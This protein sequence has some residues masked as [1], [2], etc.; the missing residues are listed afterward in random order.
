[1]SKCAVNAMKKRCVGSADEVAGTSL[2]KPRLWRVGIDGRVLRK[3][4]C[5][6]LMTGV[7]QENRA[8]LG[9]QSIDEDADEDDVDNDRRRVGGDV[10]GGGGVDEMIVGMRKDDKTQG[11]GS[12]SGWWW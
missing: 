12:G 4:T 2:G 10:E 9:F 8:V 3:G 7:I 6:G 1:M 5:K 11:G